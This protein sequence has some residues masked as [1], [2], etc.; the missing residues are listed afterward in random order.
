MSLF[1]ASLGIMT[2]GGFLALL[3]CKNPKICSFF[4]VA[5]TVVGSIV[6]LVPA[7]NVLLGGPKLSMNYTWE[8]PFGSFYIAIDPLSALFLIPIF[9]LSAVAAIYGG[10]YMLAYREKKW[11]G[12]SWFFYNLLAAGMVLVVTA[13]NGVLFLVAW[14]TMSLAS[15]FLVTFEDEHQNVRD[16]GW[17][18]LVATHLGTAFLMAFFI[19]LG[20]QT[21]SMDFNQV[22]PIAPQLS[23][24]LFFLAVIGFGTKAGFIPMHV[25]LP[26]AH[27]AAPTHV[28]A[29]M[30]GVM[31]KTGI[32]GL[33]RAI[34]LIGPPERWWCWV[35]IGIGVTSG[36]LGV[37]FA[38][39][40]QDIKRLLAYSSVEN[41]GI[42]TIGLG[43][44]LLGVNQGSSLLA[45][46]GFAGAFFHVINH[47]L[48]KGLLFLGAGSVLHG[49]KT[50]QIDRLGGLI[51]S[52][53]WTAVCFLVG[54]ISIC[55]LPPFNGFAGEFLI[56]SGVFRNGKLI[57]I[58][59]IGGLALIG[60]LAA[61]CFTKAFGVVFLG[62]PR[63]D[64]A[65]HAHEAGWLMRLA[66]TILAA[67]CFL[68]GIGAPL[69]LKAGHSVI[70]QTARISIAQTQ[71]ESAHLQGL[72]W[73]VV[74]VSLV[75]TGLILVLALLRRCLL[76]GRTV[77]QTGTWDCGYAQPTARM[78]YT[79]SSFSQ[80]LMSLFRIFLRTDL[81]LSPPR[82]LFP[83]NGSLT[84][85]TPDTSRQY[86]YHPAYQTIERLFLR[87]RWLQQGRVQL[88]VLYIALTLWILLIWK[89]R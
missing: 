2:L 66:M 17:T 4:G 63:S 50:R 76:A 39:V 83:Q 56:Y 70:A 81:K 61:A 43:V 18:Y 72:L 58:L 32:Y 41:I 60:G 19:I 6:G 33:V 10:Q 59:V 62:E 22:G 15:Y 14:E 37:L 68:A 12:G 31:I 9:G 86:I 25:W 48:F 79:A 3:T 34:L 1:L 16:A 77:T 64:S 13:R 42:I 89:L 21:G 71:A 23:S 5:G 53:P 44:G 26:E 54:A 20:R 7:I 69:I 40:Q 67:G 87:L 74:T 35:L 30:S 82:G 29:V 73:Q 8:V 55:A 27:P 78:Q 80:P 11:L 57:A 36:V 24:V 84:T 51:K 38:I 45:V 28:S 88:Y 65:M 85:H 47:A 75:L 46:A 52:M 49:C